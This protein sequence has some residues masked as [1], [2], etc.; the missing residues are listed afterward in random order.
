MKIEESVEYMSKMYLER[1][2]SFKKFI[3]KLAKRVK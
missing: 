2:K 3:F 1:I